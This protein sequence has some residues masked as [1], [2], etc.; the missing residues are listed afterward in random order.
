MQRKNFLT[1]YE[2]H[3]LIK[4]AKKINFLKIALQCNLIIQME[5]ASE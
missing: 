1:L 5:E 2:K 4:I 3:L